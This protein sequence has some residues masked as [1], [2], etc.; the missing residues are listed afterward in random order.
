MQN[1]KLPYQTRRRLE[2]RKNGN[3]QTCFKA[4]AVVGVR[5]GTSRCA[6]C[7]RKRLGIEE[8]VVTS[9][10]CDDCLCA[11]GHRAGCTA[12]KAAYEI[13]LG[14]ERED[15]EQE[16]KGNGSS[17]VRDHVWLGDGQRESSP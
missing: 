16:D 3:C 1:V 11:T 12:Q 5:G 15:T 6:A 8:P 17:G 7:D 4:K 2:A 13:S 14:D 9:S 10:W